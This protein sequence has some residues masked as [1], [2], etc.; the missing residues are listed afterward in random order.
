MADVITLT[1]DFGYDAYKI[2]RLAATEIDATDSRWIVANIGENINLY[3]VSVRDSSNVTLRGG[4]ISGEVPLDLDWVDAYV[5]S[6]AIYSRNVDGILI[7]DWTISQAW[8]A[9]RVRGNASDKFIIDNVWLSDVRDDAV[10]N[11]DGQSGII[12]NSLFDGVFVGI[13]LA[14]SDTTDQTNNVVTVD[15][16]LIRMEFFEYKGKMTHQSIFKVV[17]KISPSLRIHDSVFA[18]EDVNHAGQSRLRIAWDSV[19]NASNNYF[20]NFS[21]VP[22]PADYPWPPAGFIVLQGAAA[23]KF[24]QTARSD[25]IAVHDGTSDSGVPASDILGTPAPDTLLGTTKGENINGFDGD[26]RLYGNSGNDTLKGGLGN[27]SL[28]GG[29]GDDILEGGGGN[30]ILDGSGGNDW[31]SGGSGTDTARFTGTTAVRIN[32]SKAAAQA[33]GY[34]TDTLLSI[35]NVTSGGGGDQLTGNALANTLAFGFGNDTVRGGGGKDSLYG[36]G[37]NDRLHGG[38]S[39]DRLVGGTGKDFLWGD[40]GDDVLNGNVGRDRLSGGA[41]NDILRGGDGNDTLNGGT[42]NDR[43]VGGRG[44]DTF[45]FDTK[46]GI[47][48]IMDFAVGSDHLTFHKA[49]TGPIKDAEALVSAHV[50]VVAGNVVFDFGAGNS[51]TL[52]GIGSTAGL[53]DNILILG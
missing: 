53:A 23:R 45:V 12:R 15:N 43:M 52:Q 17:D 14:D 11:D 39:D 24:W 8:D 33:T 13:S 41:G 30:D 2:S 10:E 20:L 42:G 44:A 5:N 4:T 35:E 31:I 49:L 21:D 46:S 6:A 34:G 51:V 27:D 18:I 38:A 28:F 16:V 9:I 1:G 22:L 47:D 32:L 37:G 25:W 40:R 29:P 48:R 26:D 19:L 36:G 50:S 7:Q 3:P